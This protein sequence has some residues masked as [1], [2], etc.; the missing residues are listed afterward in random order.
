MNY[1]LKNYPGNKAIAGYYQS[2][3]NLMP[4]HDVYIEPCL[5]SGGILRK[6]KPAHLNVGSDL[7]ETIIHKWNACKL[8]KS[9]YLFHNE[10]CRQTFVRWEK[11]NSIVLFFIDLP[12]MQ[13]TRRNAR[14]LYKHESTLQLHTDVLKLITRSKQYVMMCGYD[15]ALYN[16]FLKGWNKLSVNVS[17]HGGRSAKEIIWYNFDKPKQI[18][19][20]SFLGNDFTDRQR[21]KRKVKRWVNKFSALPVLEQNLIYHELTQNRLLK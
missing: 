15:N 3:I 10:D 5:G 21:I 20:Y 7:N 11:S 9:Q 19:E 12:Y 13:E 18:S 8:D 2:V 1:P 17:I 16:G 14:K 4:P 6:K